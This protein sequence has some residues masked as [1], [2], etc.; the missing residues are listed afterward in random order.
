MTIAT[1]DIANLKFDFFPSV[2]EAV[3]HADKI[4]ALVV[5]QPEDLDN[6]SGP[7]QVAVYNA[8]VT[9]LNKFGFSLGFTKRFSDK[10]AARKRILFSLFDLFKARSEEAKKAPAAP[11]AKK[12][13]AAPKARKPRGMRFVFPAFDEIKTVREGTNRHKLIQMLSSEN[14]ATFEECLAATWGQ[15]KDMDEETQ[16]KTCYEAI[17]LIHY[18]VGY[19]MTQDE[20]GRIKL[21]TKNGK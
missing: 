10:A 21:K 20:E 3:E 17:R 9:E 18:Y 7:Q 12:E 14:G 4:D 8:L 15:K 6:L 16:R 5:K 13:K 2:G 11:K 19:G 1:I